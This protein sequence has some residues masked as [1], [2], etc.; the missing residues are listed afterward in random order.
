MSKS[1][2]GVFRMSAPRAMSGRRQM[3]D[4]DAMLAELRLCEHPHDVEV[5]GMPLHILPGVLSP[6][7]S[8]GPDA[9]MSKWYIKLGAT[10]LDLGCGS[11]VLGLAA[12][13]AGA[14][15]LVALDIN[16]Q[17][18]LTTKINIERLGYTFRADARHSDT[19]SAL[20]SGETFDVILFAAP[21]W[22]REARDELE[23]SCF[24]QHHKVMAAALKGAPLRLNDRGVMYVLFSDQ[25]EVGLVMNMI[26]E[27]KLRVRDMHVF[28]PTSPGGHIRIVWEF[29]AR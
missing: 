15:S 21:Y 23:R 13:R 29:A 19:Y 24:D 12:L 8:H 27:S 14:G 6:R 17:A 5:I 20:R 11:G 1:R 25:G 4:V 9:L 2:D 7:F 26:D 28:R 3:T 10:V 18:V 22:N 16:R